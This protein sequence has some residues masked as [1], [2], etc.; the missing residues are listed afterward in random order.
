MEALAG[1]SSEDEAPGLEVRVQ[2]PSGSAKPVFPVSGGSSGGKAFV[3]SSIHDYE[4]GGLMNSALVVAPSVANNA[5]GLGNAFTNQRISSD[6]YAPMQGPVH[7]N[8]VAGG[9]LDPAT[10]H[11]LVQR[12]AIDNYVFD[13]EYQANQGRRTGAKD[14][15]ANS[16]AAAEGPKGKKKKKNGGLQG[17]LKAI[18]DVGDE[19]SD[20]WAQPAET[21]EESLRKQA[22]FEVVNARKAELEEQKKKEEEEKVE[23]E[24][25]VKYGDG[26]EGKE[27]KSGAP[28]KA[29]EASAKFHGENVRDYQ[30]RSWTHP[31]PGVKPRDV[32]DAL[33]SEAH[34]PKKCSRKFTG[35]TKGVNAV[36]FIPGTG[37]LLLSA[38]LEGK[39]KIWDVCSDRN[40]RQTYTGHSA[41][42]KSVDFSN[43]GTQFLSSGFDRVLRLWDTETGQAVGTFGNNTIGFSVKFN[44]NDNHE[45]LVGASDNRVY[46]WDA[47]TG[48]VVQE[49]N[50]H[51][52]AVSHVNFYDEGR[53]FFSTSDDKR[54]LCWEFGVPVPT[55]YI[56]DPDMY[57]IPTCTLHPTKEC[58]AGQSMDNQVVVYSCKDPEK[59]K[60]NKKK[61]FRGHNTAGYAC[62]I[63]FSPNGQ[64]LVSG[65]GTGLMCV[66]DWK[67]SQL[68]RK[69]QAHD[70]GPCMDTAWHPLHSSWLASCGWDGVV[71]LWE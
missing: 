47:R 69:F 34:V 57:S 2:L 35:H 8:K 5:V 67:S 18:D 28:S 38:G 65:D 26:D 48:T 1:Y 25:T 22:D 42:V 11:G 27:G 46:G 43:H 36:R 61:S 52:K 19:Y 53:R 4:G 3:P 49:Y 29:I 66:W 17:A 37:H 23:R 41:A 7:P 33:T 30:G 16:G 70:H 60:V 20:P 45:F 44:P 10:R 14:K 71:K 68:F 24:A 62:G 58:F 63:S 31:P 39:C 56:A 32:E 21:S 59:V 40:V 9:G 54:I 6:V 12:T 64:Y 51:L 55:K 50:Y 13:Q 15:K